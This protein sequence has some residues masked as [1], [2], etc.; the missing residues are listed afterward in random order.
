MTL[1]RKMRRRSGAA[2]IGRAMLAVPWFILWLAPVS[3]LDNASPF[4]A[5][6]IALATVVG[7]SWLYVLRPIRHDV[8]LAAWLRLRSGGNHI[9]ALVI[10]TLSLAA[11]FFSTVAVHAKLATLGLIPPVPSG[12]SMFSPAFLEAPTGMLAYSLILVVLA[13]LV[14]ELAFRGW[15]QHHL[16]HAIGLTTALIL[17]ALLF[18]LLHG[19]LIAVHHLPFAIFAGWVVW[20]TGSL[21]PAIAMHFLHNALAFTLSA[22]D[23]GNVSSFESLASYWQLAFLIGPLTLSILFLVA[24]HIDRKAR[25]QRPIRHHPHSWWARFGHPAPPPGNA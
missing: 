1:T 24:R 18:S 4:W 17:P 9:V 10:A 19:F 15:M 20:R 22:H 25:L 8:R 5:F 11:L 23:S 16:E 2:A 14:E 6:C 13:P 7:V 3:L 21:W 12:E